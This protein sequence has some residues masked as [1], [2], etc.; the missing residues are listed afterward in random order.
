M[1]ESFIDGKYS[2]YKEMLI[3]ILDD[4]TCDISELVPDWV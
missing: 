3:F 4:I 1:E 2:V